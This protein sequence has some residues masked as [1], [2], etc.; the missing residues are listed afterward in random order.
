MSCFRVVRIVK[1]KKHGVEMKA[2]R[3]WQRRLYHL[4]QSAI[5]A[6]DLAKY[7]I[8]NSILKAR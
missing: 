2:D 6:M 1:K 3:I 8:A 7:N 5:A 4:F